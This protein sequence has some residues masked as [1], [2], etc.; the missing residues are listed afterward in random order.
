MP[1]DR[2]L[3]ELVARLLEAGLTTEEV[4]AV[5]EHRQLPKAVQ[6]Q[7][8]LGVVHSNVFDDR[9]APADEFRNWIYARHGQPADTY[10]P[11]AD[12]VTGVEA[13]RG[14]P[15][16]GVADAA[17]VG[18]EARRRTEEQQVAAMPDGVH[19]DRP[20]P[21]PA[22]ASSAPGEPP[23]GAVVTDAQTRVWIR[24][25]DG[26]WRQP[27][28]GG[29]VDWAQ[30]TAFAGPNAGPTVISVPPAETTRRMRPG[31]ARDMPITVQHP[32]VVDGQPMLDARGGPVLRA[33]EEQVGV[34]ELI[35]DEQP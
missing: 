26:M 24:E 18:A 17:A 7:P 2:K 3:V 15:R 32:V 31:P 5:L 30:L 10:R 6:P 28:T 20:P 35:P 25:Q 34:A 13:D 1:D 22:A 8:S 16:V 14:W 19:D 29:G 21:P 11:P 4:V 23:V 9:R 12:L 27:G 33:V